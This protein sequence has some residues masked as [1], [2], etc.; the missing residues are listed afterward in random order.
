M[1]NFALGVGAASA[2]VMGTNLVRNFSLP[3]SPDALCFF[4]SSYI[5]FRIEYDLR[6]DKHLTDPPLHWKHPQKGSERHGL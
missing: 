1:P 3:T 5:M 6:Q 4:G 2:E